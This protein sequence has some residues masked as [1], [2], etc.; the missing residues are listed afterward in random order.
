MEPQMNADEHGLNQIT[1]KIIGR[2]YHVSNTIGCGFLEKVYE[3]AMV[4]ALRQI[5]LRVEQQVRFPVV[6]E[7]V[8]VGEYIADLVIEGI[9]L[10]EIKAVKA[11]DEIH[12]A[13]CLNQIRASNLPICLLINFAEARLALKRVVGPNFPSS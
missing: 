11:F 4:V 13:Q 3:N 6:F 9:I 10:V 2:A 12:E 5:G 8:V 1:E 7:G